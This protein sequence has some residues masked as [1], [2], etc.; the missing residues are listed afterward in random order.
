MRIALNKVELFVD[1]ERCDLGDPC[2]EDNTCRIHKIA[3][4]LRITRQTDPKEE[5][6]RNWH[7]ACERRDRAQHEV[8]AAAA[9]LKTELAKKE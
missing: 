5:A 4:Y 2:S 6:R 7:A 8:E 1:L 3:W 9:I